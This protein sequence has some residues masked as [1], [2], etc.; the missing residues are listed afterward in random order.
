MNNFILE[1][2]INKKLNSKNFNDFAPNGLQIEGCSKIEKIIFGVTACQK[3]LDFAV[4]TKSH[5][6]IVHHG[7]F[8]KNESRSITGMKK[9]RIKTIL[10]NNINLYSWHLPLDVHPKIGNN[11]QI[12]KKLNIKILGTFSKFG[13][14]G[15]FNNHISGEKLCEL[16]QNKFG[17]KPIYCYGENSPKKINT[18][19]WCSGKGQS[20]IYK[21]LNL[22]VDAY[23]TGE[24]SEDTMHCANEN[25]IHFFSI[26]HHASEKFGILELSNWV[27][28]K[29]N[30]DCKFVNINNPA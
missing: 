30:L 1:N 16:I 22:Q 28:S 8:W 25:N 15:K 5:A 23:I 21:A 19:A 27:C 13:L 17:K 4:K 7:Y 14:F 6:V 12:A 29:Y 2:I 9:N 3:L 20:Y 11:V 24:I 18:V 26:G 10:V